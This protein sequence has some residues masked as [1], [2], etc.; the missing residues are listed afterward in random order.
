MFSL[1]RVQD[2]VG[3]I[4]GSGGQA[5]GV[6]GDITNLDYVNR[7]V[8]EAAEFGNGKIHIIVNN[9]GYTWDGVIHKMSDKQWD[10]IVD[11]H[12]KAPFQLIRAAAPYFRVKDGQQRNIVGISST[13]GINGN[14]GQINYSLVKAGVSGMVKTIAKEWGPSF[15][16][17]ANAIAFGHIKTRLTQAKEKGAFALSPDGEK[18]KLGVPGR[19]DDS[20]YEDIPLRRPGMPGDAAGAILAVCS[21]LFSYVTGQTIMVTGGRNM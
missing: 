5:L 18:I 10:T 21:P 14:A 8:S 2:V 4:N 19:K 1:G 13:S 15:N 11:L 3:D 20:T 12:G 17:R 16:V 9:A 6:P 7:L